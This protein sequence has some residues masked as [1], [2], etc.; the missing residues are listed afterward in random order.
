MGLLTR[1]CKD[2][3]SSLLQQ[4]PNSPRCLYNNNN[5]LANS[6]TNSLSPTI[7]QG[8][9]LP[10]N[11]VKPF[12]RRRN[13]AV[14]TYQAH[15]LI[16]LSTPHIVEARNN[17]CRSVLLTQRILLS[18]PDYWASSFRN[19]TNS[20]YSLIRMLSS[21]REE[22]AWFL[23]WLPIVKQASYRRKRA[24]NSLW[25]PHVLAE[26]GA[27]ASQLRRLKIRT[28]QS[29]DSTITTNSWRSTKVPSAWLASLTASLM[30]K[31][32]KTRSTQTAWNIHVQK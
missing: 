5:L 26:A 32:G 14:P 8:D 23:I 22:G 13:E 19:A 4:P 27:S 25:E 10:S 3:S 6:S 17:Y 9:S 2:S 30:T 24:R 21:S 7:A 15:C 28:S 12:L 11:R 31:K 18:L 20:P 16:A 29:A 1:W